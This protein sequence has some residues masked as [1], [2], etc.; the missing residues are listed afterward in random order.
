MR[1]SGDLSFS[2]VRGFVKSIPLSTNPN[3]MAKATT[4]NPA[5]NISQWNRI[6]IPR[7]TNN[8]EHEP[9]K[10][11]RAQTTGSRNHPGPHATQTLLFRRFE[12][13]FDLRQ[14]VFGDSL[15]IT[16]VF[17]FANLLSKDASD[18]FTRGDGRGGD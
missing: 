8:G 11:C 13:L 3:P 10:N 15:Q 16:R 14:D 12:E 9:N 17:D 5:K 1:A 2:P 18:L 7:V 4:P 6:R